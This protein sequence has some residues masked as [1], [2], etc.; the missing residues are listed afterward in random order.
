MFMT[1]TTPPKRGWR[2]SA[3]GAAASCR[4]KRLMNAPRIVVIGLGY[5]GLPLAVAL[6]RKYDVIGFDI[7]GERIDELRDGRDRTREVDQEELR[8]STL[9][10]GVEGERCAGADVYIIS[11]PTP[12]D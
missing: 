4:P 1:A 12:V 10:L 9:K 3:S 6:A 2:I 8:Q 7:D 11:V 5:V